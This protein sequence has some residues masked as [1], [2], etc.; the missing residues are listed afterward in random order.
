MFSFLFY[1]TW[2][3]GSI[4]ILGTIGLLSGWQFDSSIC[5][6][7]VDTKAEMLLFSSSNFH[8]F[9]LVDGSTQSHVDVQVHLLNACLFNANS[10]YKNI[11]PI[12][13]VRFPMPES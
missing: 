6:I 8:T 7:Q 3:N 13:S 4:W 12:G 10:L 11:H 1:S 2:R 9:V 5:N